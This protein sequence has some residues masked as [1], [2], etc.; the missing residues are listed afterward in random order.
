MSYK[1]KLVLVITILLTITFSLGASI[2]IYRTYQQSFEREEKEAVESLQRVRGIIGIVADGNE[3]F[4]DESI[5]EMMK[6]L[7]SEGESSDIYM[8]YKDEA[9]L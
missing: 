9:V 7:E 3:E 2:I 5:I 1:L 4:D 6:K 8:L